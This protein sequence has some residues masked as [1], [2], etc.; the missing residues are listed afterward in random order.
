ML[1][2]ALRATHIALCRTWFNGTFA[3]HL[4]V[5]AGLTHVVHAGCKLLRIRKERAESAAIVAIP[6]RP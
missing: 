1:L 5:F 6:Q 4:L 3:V 2:R